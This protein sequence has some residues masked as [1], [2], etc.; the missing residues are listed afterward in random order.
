MNSNEKSY[1]SDSLKVYWK[2]E[3]CEHAG[4]CVKGL[5]NVFNV[6]HKP[7]ISI[8]NAKTKEIMLVIDT[9][10]SKALSYEMKNKGI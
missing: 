9:C 3:I 1:E 4:K 6:N 5:P 2:P 10:Q 8:E 7:W